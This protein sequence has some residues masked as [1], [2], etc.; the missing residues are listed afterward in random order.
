MNEL[1]FTF[2]AA[3]EELL[4]TM[5][6]L[7]ECSFIGQPL[8]LLE[9]YDDEELQ[10]Y[11]STITT[12]VEQISTLLEPLRAIDD[13][14]TEL[15]TKDPWMY[16]ANI[17]KQILQTI[18]GGMTLISETAKL[19]SKEC[20]LLITSSNQHTT[21]LAI[22]NKSQPLEDNPFREGTPETKQEWQTLTQRY[23]ETLKT[24]IAESDELRENFSDLDKLLEQ[25]VAYL[26]RDQWLKTSTLSKEL[27][28]FTE[29]LTKAVTELT[30][31]L[32]KNNYHLY[33]SGALHAHLLLNYPPKRATTQEKKLE[34]KEEQINE[35]APSTTNL[36]LIKEEENSETKEMDEEIELKGKT[37]RFLQLVLIA[38]AKKRTHSI[39]GAWNAYVRK[40][41]VA[42]LE[43]LGQKGLPDN[44]VLWQQFIDFQDDKEPVESYLANLM[45]ELVALKNK[46]RTILFGITTNNNTAEEENLSL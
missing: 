44:I 20:E 43:K 4:Q 11:L 1:L 12:I 7:E 33:T 18:N 42:F 6:R 23:E 14:T 36:P 25:T 27:L 8:D 46:R 35:Q 39:I 10:R 24:L 19:H 31:A 5:Q 30:N 34:D 40:S 26:E 9:D 29:S 28:S 32:E 41:G 45:A 13:H 16:N 2:R 22:L 37:A 17:H 21:I 15:V 3:E 38:Y